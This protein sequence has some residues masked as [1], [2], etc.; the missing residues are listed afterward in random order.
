[1]SRW[2]DESAVKYLVRNPTMDATQLRRSRRAQHFQSPLRKV[3]AVTA[4]TLPLYRG[5]DGT[6][7]YWQ[8]ASGI[9]F[10]FAHGD[11]AVAI[12]AKSSA[13]I[14]RDHLK[15]LRSLLVDRPG[16]AH[17]LVVC[18]EPKL[19]RTDERHPDPARQHNCAKPVFG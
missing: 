2:M 13:K 5:H 8:L 1:M 6:V 16:V 17:R 18:H 4:S 10:G 19:R 12:E 7:S 14:A 15:G 3:I 11:M 9:E